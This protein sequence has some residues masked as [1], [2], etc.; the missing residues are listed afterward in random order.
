MPR[1]SPRNPETDPAALLGKHLRRVRIAAGYKIQ[2]P[3]AA[4]AHIS[5]DQISR[6]ETGN[7]PPTDDL[8][9]AWMKLCGVTDPELE[10]F[11]DTLKLARNSKGLVVEGFEPWLN[12]EREASFIRAWNPMLIPGLLQVGEYALPLFRVMGKSREKAAEL[13]DIRLSR[14]DILTSPDPLTGVFVVDESVLYRLVESPDVMVKQ[15]D[16][17]LA[18]SEQPNVTIQIV[19]GAASLAGMF[20]AF[21]L[22]NGDGA[23]DTMLIW[24]VQDQTTS[25]SALVR[26][27]IM[28][29][30]LIR[31]RALN[32]QESRAALMEARQQWA[33]QQ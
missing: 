25:D 14:Q 26:E 3:F 15:L 6:A 16:R 1:V 11:K 5:Q 18:L 31:G 23:P 32:V 9:D 28:I 10:W 27:A 19:R 33:S 29:F 17:M 4:A 20:G 30:E 21:E 22:A 24:A 8:F 12:I 2:D 7:Q 13:L